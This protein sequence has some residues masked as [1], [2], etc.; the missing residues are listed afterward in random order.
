MASVPRV[1]LSDPL[2]GPTP[3]GGS[4]APRLCQDCSHPIPASPGRAVL[5]SY[6]TATTAQRWRSSTSTQIT[7]ASRR[8]KPALNA[9][10]ITFEGR[11]FP[12]D[13]K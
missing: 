10:A 6:R 3:S 13:T 9:F 5:S 7:S 8:T 4:G 12:N 1:L 11:I 2:T